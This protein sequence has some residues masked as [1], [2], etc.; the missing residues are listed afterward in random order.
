MHIIIFDSFVVNISSILII[1][2]FFTTSFDFRSNYIL[3]LKLSNKINMKK[4][5]S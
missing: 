1:R 2:E 3:L 4:L 5:L